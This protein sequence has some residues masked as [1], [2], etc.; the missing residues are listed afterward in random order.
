M[1]ETGGSA[2]G[3]LSS[4]YILIAEDDV[5]S[6]MSLAEALSGGYTVLQAENGY[7][8]L[9]LYE[10]YKTFIAAVITDIDMPVM[11]GLEF[12]RQIR[13]R[14]AEIPVIVISGTC[15]DDIRRQLSE[16]PDVRRY[17]KPFRT[18]EI[19]AVLKQIIKNPV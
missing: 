19:R 17:S 4:L 18:Q 8:A 7:E 9:L 11:D 2:D 13:S 5:L 3:K 14:G 1:D 6:R 10:Q 15:D 12:V 16:I